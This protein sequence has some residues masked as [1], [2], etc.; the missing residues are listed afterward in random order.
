[1]NVLEA[2]CQAIT[3]IDPYWLTAAQ[4]R[5]LTLTKPPG[6]LGCL[7]TVGNRI[8]AIAQ[9]ATPRIMKKRIFVAAADHGVTREGISAY[10]REVTHQMVL[11]FLSG[12]AA[13]NVLARHCGIEVEVVDAGVDYDFPANLP[14]ANRKITRG[15]SNM[16]AGP[17]MS[18]D[19]A[20]QAIAAGVELAGRA[21]SDGVNLIGIGEMG[22]GN[23][24]AASA[25]TA[26]L[27]GEE[28]DAVT[29]RGTGVD[30]QMLARKRRV[31]QTAI[32]V[33]RPDA[34]DPLDVLQKVGGLEIAVMMGITLGAAAERIAIVSDGFIST[35]A[36]A[37]AVAACPSVGDYLFIGHL[38]AEPGHRALVEYIGAR[39]LL[40]LGMRLGEGTG[41]ALA[42]HIIEASTRVLSEMTTFEQAGVADKEV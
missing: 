42:M 19:H 40:D 16:A 3:P 32:D 12:G 20:L 8:A 36:A 11:N 17:A 41:A 22:I 31:I 33:N 37:L 23:T 14:L 15:T 4:S 9:S 38:S 24:T 7:E 35:A 18:R 6:S 28:I 1:M 2:T 25:I 29:G 21:K 10:P 5:Q 34:R 13:I 26:L 30:D 39:P 27:T